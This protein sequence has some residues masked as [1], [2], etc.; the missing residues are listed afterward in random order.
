M[1]LVVADQTGQEAD[2]EGRAEPDAEPSHHPLVVQRRAE[3]ALVRWCWRL[4]LVDAKGA[5]GRCAGAQHLR[6]ADGCRSRRDSG[7]ADGRAHGRLS[8]VR[9][10]ARAA[11]SSP[12][13][14]MLVADAAVARWGDLAHRT[15]AGRC[16][17]GSPGLAFGLGAWWVLRA[18]RRHRT[19]AGR[20]TSLRLVVLLAAVLQLPGLFAGQHITQRRLPLRLGR[21]GAA[22][23]RL[24][25]P[26][27]AARRPPGPPARPAALPRSAA[28]PAS[29]VGTVHKLPS[30][31]HQL[32][33]LATQDTRTRINHSR[34][35]TIYP[36]VAEAWFALV[37]LVTPWS[38]GTHGL[39]VGSALLAVGFTCPARPLVRPARRATRGA[40]CCGGGARR[41]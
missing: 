39:Q 22:V 16:S 8:G 20:R 10:P 31:K 17:P 37:A 34:V 27:L 1:L 35:T 18:P 2:Q 4:H 40:R 13:V 14:P 23:R 36:P 33:L 29:G 32:Q 21:A 24:A 12:A 6:A 30:D 28:G 15:P 7:R 5:R 41:W 26:V 25:L 11:C 38:W 19:P 9:L 3:V